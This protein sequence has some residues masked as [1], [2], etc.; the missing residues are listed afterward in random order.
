[1]FG[2]YV[3]RL[4]RCDFSCSA[5]TG[6]TETLRCDLRPGSGSTFIFLTISESQYRAVPK[7]NIT[8]SVAE[9][10]LE[11]NNF[12]FQKN[13]SINR[14]FS[15]LRVGSYQVLAIDQLQTG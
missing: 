3:I 2:T 12:L 9:N 10:I 11:R 8:G 15:Y 14:V 4:G 1:M 13:M 5:N 7:E 6:Q